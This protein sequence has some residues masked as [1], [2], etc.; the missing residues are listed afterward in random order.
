MNKW[1]FQCGRNYVFQGVLHARMMSS[2]VMNATAFQIGG[3][4]I[5]SPIVMIGQ[6]KKTAVSPK[7]FFPILAIVYIVLR[8]IILL[9]PKL[10]II[11]FKELC[12]HSF[13]HDGMSTCISN[14]LQAN[15][16]VWIDLMFW[17]WPGIFLWQFKLSVN[18]LWYI[19][20][21][22]PKTELV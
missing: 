21:M 15:W 10:I 18:M 4:A 11:Y 6:M 16:N 7:W 8:H 1:H 3:Y 14:W 19:R 2:L 12:L 5:T 17:N 13:V 22:R 9:Y 20:I